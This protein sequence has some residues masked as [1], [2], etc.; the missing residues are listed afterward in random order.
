MGQTW[1][2]PDSEKPPPPSP[3]GAAYVEFWNR[4]CDFQNLLQNLQAFL[5][6]RFVPE[7]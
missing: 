5:L 4:G 1:V 6:S 2:S 7:L 3:L